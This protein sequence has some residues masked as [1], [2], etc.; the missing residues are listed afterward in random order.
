M[1]VTEREGGRHRE[2]QV[3]K[4]EGAKSYTHSGGAAPPHGTRATPT[5]ATEKKLWKRLP[6]PAFLLPCLKKM[7]MNETRGGTNEPR[8]TAAQLI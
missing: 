8:M 7:E 2:R 1:V 3:Q 4:K 6:L 5:T